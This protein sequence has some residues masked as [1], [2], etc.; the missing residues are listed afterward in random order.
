[1][2]KKGVFVRLHDLI[3]EFFQRIRAHE[4]DKVLREKMLR[5]LRIIIDSQNCE[6]IVRFYGALFHDV[7][8][9]I[10]ILF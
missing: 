2:A 8:T 6:D 10:L 9:N 1:M 7:S 4:I 5:E 3:K